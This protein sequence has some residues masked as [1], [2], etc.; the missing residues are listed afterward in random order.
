[1]DE[2]QTYRIGEHQIELAFRDGIAPVS[3]YSLLLA[4][5]IPNLAGQTV[6]DLG[7]GSG[8][9]AAVAKLQGAKRVY[10]VDSFCRA[11]ALALENAKRN[12]IE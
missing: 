3:P 4:E 10:L 7:T 1:M 11:V 12:G 9:L 8:L 6:I 5:N 2:V